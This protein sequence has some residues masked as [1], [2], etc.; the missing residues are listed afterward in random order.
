MNKFLNLAYKGLGLDPEG[1]DIGTARFIDLP[2]EVFY[3]IC[4]HRL[5]DVLWG[6]HELWGEDDPEWEQIAVSDGFVLY[7]DWQYMVKN[8]RSY[9]FGNEKDPTRNALTPSSSGEPCGSTIC[10]A[11]TTTSTAG[12]AISATPLPS[13]LNPSS[14]KSFPSGSRERRC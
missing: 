8:R 6:L 9:T 7:K 3:T 2:P 12:K 1:Y 4:A 13:S 5:E 14:S 11:M 10:T